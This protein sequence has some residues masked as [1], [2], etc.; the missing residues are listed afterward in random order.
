MRPDVFSDVDPMYLSAIDKLTF[1]IDIDTKERIHNFGWRFAV[2]PD[3]IKQLKTAKAK[4]ASTGA[5]DV[6][7]ASG[8]FEVTSLDDLTG[9]DLVLES[10]ILDKNGEPTERWNIS[11][12]QWVGDYP[13]RF[14]DGWLS[15]MLIYTDDEPIS[16]SDMVEELRKIRKP[17]NWIG[18]II[19][20]I[21]KHINKKRIN[22]S[23]KYMAPI[24]ESNRNIAENAKEIQR[25]SAEVERAKREGNVAQEEQLKV[26]LTRLTGEREKLEMTRREIDAEFERN[27]VAEMNAREQAEMGMSSPMYS[28]IIS[29][30]SGAGA[31]AGAGGADDE[32]LRGAVMSFNAKMLDKYGSSPE[33]I[34]STESG[35]QS[36]RTPGTPAYSSSFQYGGS[37]GG[38]SRFIPQIPM[39]VLESYLNSRQGKHGGA[40]GGIV[41]G[42]GGGSGGG[43]GFPGM[44]QMQM[45][46]AGAMMAPTMNVPLIATMPMTMPMTMQQMAAPM[47]MAAPA[48]ST[49]ATGGSG[50]N[51]SANQA[52]NPST[53]PNAE[54]VKTLSIKI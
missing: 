2:K 31:G 44:Q 40:A 49:V 18:A 42:G 24:R 6:A 9:S 8:E 32:T 23:D 43:G 45:G 25:I 29:P 22:E 19:S 20:L 5:F 12:A 27:R 51:N 54:G 50:G 3:I 28:S 13:T 46:G 17:L 4:G 26:Q 1:D 38:T 41:G 11:G 37:S 53:Q 21:E 47:Q 16:P 39:G 52:N 33:D 7:G 34:P 35:N 48:A 30:R 14:P 10:V 36:P 15:G